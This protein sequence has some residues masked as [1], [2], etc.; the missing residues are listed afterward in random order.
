MLG[1][2]VRRIAWLVVSLAVIFFFVQAVV[3]PAGAILRP[4]DKD[5]LDSVLLVA[6][7]AFLFGFLFRRVRWIQHI[8]TWIHEFGHAVTASLLGGVPTKIQ[9]NKDSSGA[10]H[11]SPTQRPS[12]FKFFFV[13]AAGPLA[14]TITFFIAMIFTSR[15]QA[16][17]VML[18]SS[19]I[20][21][22]VLVTTVRSVW[23]WFVGLLVWGTMVFVTSLANDWF[24]GPSHFLIQGS[25]LAAMTG[26][27]AGV[28]T[29]ASIRM[30]RVNGPYGDEGKI[31][32]ILRLPEGLVDFMIVVINIGFA[33]LAF[34]ALGVFGEGYFTTTAP[35]LLSDVF[36]QIQS[37]ITSL[38][39]N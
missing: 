17:N 24:L 2:L 35:A 32:A 15:G 3:P 39:G 20:V 34:A 7:V 16:A 4:L 28:A 29:R 18:V 14:S 10:T 31:A 36:N 19:A 21:L 5:V 27:A 22:L 30:M 33:T 38:V 37:W 23:G 12:K 13:C 8:D 11:F 1:R 25:F 6:T 26:I 9:L